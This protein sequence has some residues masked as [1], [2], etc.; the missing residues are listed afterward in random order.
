MYIDKR[1]RIHK[2]CES[3]NITYDFYNEQI[4]KNLFVCIICKIWKNSDE[5][6]FDNGK[7]SAKDKRYNTCKKCK[8]LYT[9]K[10]H[11]LPDPKRLYRQYK[12]NA[13]F[14]GYAFELELEDF[15]QL[16][17]SECNYCGDKDLTLGYDRI[18]NDKGYIKSN[19]IPCCWNCNHMKYKFSTME[20]MNHMKKILMHLA[21]TNGD[22][23]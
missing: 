19:I 22:V 3:L 23:V 21:E 1:T 16:S 13:E 10:R 17:T 7:H 18:D 8:S 6:S 14:R 4:N 11:L 15:K 5:F 20:W 9:R 12:A 2:I